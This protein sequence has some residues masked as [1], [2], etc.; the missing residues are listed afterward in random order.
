MGSMRRES[1]LVLVLTDRESLP[2]AVKSASDKLNALE[3]RQLDHIPQFTLDIRHIDGP[4]NEVDGAFSRPSIAL[5]QLL[6]GI[7]LAERDAEQCGLGSSCDEDV[8]GLQLQD[9]PLNTG[10]GAT[11]CGVS[12]SSHRLL[13]RHPSAANSSPRT[14][15]PTL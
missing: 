7:D 2:L 10:N 1:P 13:F 9:L 5:L 8:S 14:T 11:L 12:T 15:Y 3:I 6:P 4:R